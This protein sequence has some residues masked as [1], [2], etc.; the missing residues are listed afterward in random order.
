MKLLFFCPRW[1]SDNLCWEKFLTQVKNAGF[2]GVEI[3]L[4]E[5]QKEAEDLITL[6]KR[7]QLKYV[8]QHYETKI[9]DFKKHK[10]EYLGHLERA[11]THKPYLINSHTGRDF[12][13]YTQNMELL[14]EAK[15]I[16]EINNVVISHETHR[17]RFSFAAHVIEKYLKHDWLKLTW[18]V[19]HWFCVAETLLVEQE[20]VITKTIPHIQH[21]HAR[22]GHTQGP[23]VD[24]PDHPK[25]SETKERHLKLW[26]DVILNHIQ[27]GKMELGITTEFGPWP[28]M[29]FIPSGKT[30]QT[31]Q[32][33]LNV[34]MMKVL[35]T[36]YK[37]LL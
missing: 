33:E 31:H 27:S 10:K 4:P 26:D 23:Q 6:I 11:G 15:H 25:W 1:G 12:F 18:D 3:G 8:L 35:K 5:N 16:S 30:F 29:Q 36:R 20:P 21:I 32:F 7:Y 22:I 14:L 34:N 2:D 19:S 13:T 17:S 24:D 9:P 28:Y 37:N